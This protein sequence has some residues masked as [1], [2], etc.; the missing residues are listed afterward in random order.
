M[1]EKR[2][3]LV[4]IALIGLIA[5]FVYTAIYQSERVQISGTVFSIFPES[6][7]STLD[8]EELPSVLLVV[9]GE[10]GGFYH[11]RKFGKAGGV[12]LQFKQGDKVKFSGYR[13]LIPNWQYGERATDI[14]RSYIEPVE[15]G[16]AEHSSAF[17]YPNLTKE[18][19]FV[20]L[21]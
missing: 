16:P 3:L 18:G 10:D 8:F 21:F 6:G 12:L 14:M 17:F 15:A 2:H 4:F 9:R 5:T 11:I 1:F 19:P 20:T 7:T 13:Q